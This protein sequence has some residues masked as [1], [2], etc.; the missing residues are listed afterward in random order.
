[1]HDKDN[2]LNNAELSTE[3]NRNMIA[4]VPSLVRI[5]LGLSS[6]GSSQRVKAFR[7]KID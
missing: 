7:P 2:Y 3:Q 1:M 4:N 6:C 5:R